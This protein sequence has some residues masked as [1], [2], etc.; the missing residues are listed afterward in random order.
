MNLDAD[1]VERIGGFLL[2][3][4][5]SDEFCHLYVG[6]VVAPPA[7]G[8]GIAGYGG[9]I[10]ENEDIR[11]RVWAA[12]E[13]IEAAFAGCFTNSDHRDR[14]VLAGGQTQ[15]ATAKMDDG[16][17]QRLFLDNPALASTSATVVASGPDGIVLDRTVFYARGGGQP[18]DSGWL[19]WDG[20]E[21][22]ITEAVKG[23]G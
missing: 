4:G 8:E 10:S 22:P 23:R 14:P 16:M 11:V 18:G 17:T 7:D 3:A 5:G 21:T 15:R 9:E 2:T 1:L 13:A 19:R 20:G 12:E 6:R